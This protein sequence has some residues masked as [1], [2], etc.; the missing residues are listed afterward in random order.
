[1]TDD[2]D[3]YRRRARPAV[4]LAIPATIREGL[5]CAAA[6]EAGRWRMAR[7]DGRHFPV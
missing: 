4:E 5:Q 3:F 7:G 2:E 6:L 1:V